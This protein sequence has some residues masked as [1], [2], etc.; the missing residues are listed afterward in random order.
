[1]QTE[2]KKISVLVIDDDITNASLVKY[3]LESYSSC[4]FTVFSEDNGT[5]A[6]QTLKDHPDID[7]VLMDFY[8]GEETGLVIIKKMT[9]EHINIP[10]VFLTSHKDYRSAVEAMKYG[11]EDYILKDTNMDINL[12]KTVM[13]ILEN[14]RLKKQREELEK[15]NYISLKR[16]EAI[17]ELVVTM[18]HEFNNPLAAIKIS[19]AIIQ[20]QEISEE[21]K[22][23]IERL[24]VDITHLENQ[25]KVLR[26]I[27]IE[28]ISN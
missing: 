1:M 14:F 21:Q 22:S 27:N 8:L 13:K 15:Q 23:I 26:D 7:L 6:I 16:T 5:Q 17:K 25:L 20:R 3:L 4:Q 24:N 18:C 10:V 11:V 19:T 28:G 12:P 2:E 9:E